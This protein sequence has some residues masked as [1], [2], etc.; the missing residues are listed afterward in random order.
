[1]YPL[2]NGWL[3]LL[4][5]NKE[6]L[7]SEKNCSLRLITV[8]YKEKYSL[9]NNYSTLDHS[10]SLW[11][12]FYYFTKIFVRLSVIAAVCYF[13]VYK[14]IGWDSKSTAE[15]KKKE[16]KCSKLTFKK[17][18]SHHGVFI[19]NFEHISH[20]IFSVSILDFEWV[21]VCVNIITQSLK[22]SKCCI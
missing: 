21:N 18:K 15:H 1:M 19:V 12:C 14:L 5:W 3:Q 6:T 20:S 7:Y 8:T 2:S 17:I 10:L 13:S 11:V 9:G 22:I 16:W 4:S